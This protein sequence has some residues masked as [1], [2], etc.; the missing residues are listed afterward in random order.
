VSLKRKGTYEKKEIPSSRGRETHQ[1]TH[2]Q[3]KKGRERDLV[4]QNRGECVFVPKD[5][6]GCQ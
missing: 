4:N 6:A 1:G 2:S 3:K 5:G